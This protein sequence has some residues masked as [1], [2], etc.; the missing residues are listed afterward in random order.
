MSEIQN[1]RVYHKE[2]GKFGTI[3]K[4]QGILGLKDSIAIVFDDGTKKA[5]FGK[6]LN[7]VVC[8]SDDCND[9]P[10]D[11]IAI[12][13]NEL[14]PEHSSKLIKSYSEL[15]DEDKDSVRTRWANATKRSKARFA[16]K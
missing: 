6:G 11:I 8:V 2:S 9:I 4:S 3:V 10:I 14:K 1:K 12:W 15:S 13:K 5:Y 16:I 7:A